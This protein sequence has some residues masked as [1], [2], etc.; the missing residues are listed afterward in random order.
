MVFFQPSNQSSLLDF[1]GPNAK[2]KRKR[3]KA[4]EEKD[5]IAE[6][7]N[8]LDSDTEDSADPSRTPVAKRKCND[9][10]KNNTRKGGVIVLDSDCDEEAFMS[11]EEKEKL[12]R[13]RAKTKRLVQ[14]LE[15]SLL[16]SSGEQRMESDTLHTEDKT[17]HTEDK[18]DSNEP[19]VEEDVDDL[20][21]ITVKRRRGRTTDRN[22]RKRKG[23]E[24]RDDRDNKDT[25]GI[26]LKQNRVGHL[27]AAK[28]TPGGSSDNAQFKQLA[29][30][31]ISVSSVES[32][33]ASIDRMMTPLARNRYSTDEKSNHNETRERADADAMLKSNH[34]VLMRREQS[35]E[36]TDAESQSSSQSQVFDDEDATRWSCAVCTFLNH[37][38]LTSCEMCNSP[39][40]RKTR[41]VTRLKQTASKSTKKT[42]TPGGSTSKNNS[43]LAYLGSPVLGGSKKEQTSKDISRTP[44]S[45]KAIHSANVGSPDI[46]HTPKTSRG[47]KI[48]HKT[49]QRATP[50]E[51]EAKDDV[52]SERDCVTP[53]ASTSGKVLCSTPVASGSSRMAFKVIKSLKSLLEADTSPN[54]GNRVKRAF[55]KVHTDEGQTLLTPSCGSEKSTLMTAKAVTDKQSDLC[56]SEKLFDD[57]SHDVDYTQETDNEGQSVSDNKEHSVSDNKV[58]SISDH[59]KHSISDNEEHSIS[60]HEKHSMSDHEKHSIS[61]HEK[62]SKAHSVSDNDFHSVSDNDLHS[63]SDIESNSEMNNS[64]LSVNNAEDEMDES[65]DT[66]EFFDVETEEN[67]ASHCDMEIGADTDVEQKTEP[68]GSAVNKLGL[69][70]ERRHSGDSINDSQSENDVAVVRESVVRGCNTKAKQVKRRV[71]AVHTISDSESEDENNSKTRNLNERSQTKHAVEITQ[72]SPQVILSRDSVTMSSEK[73]STQECSEKEIEELIEAETEAAAQL[74]SSQQ[75]KA[76][77]V[78]GGCPWVCPECDLE[79]D[80]AVEDCEGCLASKPEQTSTSGKE[81]YA[82]LPIFHGLEIYHV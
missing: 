20:P 18:Q 10:P 59:E 60:D 36:D 45:S 9:F 65:T 17:L 39:H 37:D 47:Q 58:H 74:F 81:N 33:R 48:L 38:M 63:V 52:S 55:H 35:E 46:L 28:Q 67:G 3:K 15:Q 44:K 49:P 30:G 64:L 26:T 73:L 34:N 54:L 57:D 43:M 66:Q 16:D 40:T 61:D 51:S 72:A 32:N 82:L 78:G 76:S 71:S 75:S 77:T 80:A 70:N 27:Q 68:S 12:A 79:N 13:K 62:Y 22:N 56:H 7:I 23:D 21:S 50:I 2:K 8:I 24:D 6:E 29:P 53:K 25:G 19:L 4:G 41:R 42:K 1:F 11:P 14:S 31:G 69:T 5:E